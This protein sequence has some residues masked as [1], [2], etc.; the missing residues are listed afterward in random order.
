[1]A[2]RAGEEKEAKWIEEQTG[3]KTIAAK[4]GMTIDLEESGKTEKTEIASGSA[5]R[6]L[7]KWAAKKK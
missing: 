4:D 3:V 1:L 2:L 7:E 6:G 5:G